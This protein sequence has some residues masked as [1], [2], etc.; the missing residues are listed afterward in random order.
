MYCLPV[1]TP[2]L[3]QRQ[4]VENIEMSETLNTFEL[5][6]RNQ[7][8]QD[9]N[10]YEDKIESFT[11][12]AEE[13]AQILGVNRSRLSQLTS[14][15]IFTFE[16]RKIDTRNRLFYKLTELLNHQRSQ[17]QGN[18]YVNALL[19]KPIKYQTKEIETLSN[20]IELDETPITKKQE[21]FGTKSRREKKTL[22]SAKNLY[23]ADLNTQ[24][25]MENK[26]TTLFIK[27]KSII[28]EELIHTIQQNSLKKD[29]LINK[30][31]QQN[32]DE[33]KKLLYSISLLNSQI[34]SLKESVNRCEINLINN[35]IKRKTSWKNK[36]AKYLP[37]STAS[38]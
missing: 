4:L 2:N 24:E 18:P 20:D 1:Y 11:I 5:P 26:E 19:E 21:Q 6:S 30:K 8:L 17:M 29:G 9:I 27:E 25:K 13:A 10:S 7:N 33:T 32:K 28:Q 23:L 38:R 37:K 16:R 15:G 12:G 35:T 34:N 14:K 36:K 3:S 31:I 22:P